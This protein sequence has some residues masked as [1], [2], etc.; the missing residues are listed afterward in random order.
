MPSEQTLEYFSTKNRPTYKQNFILKHSD[1]QGIDHLSNKQNDS[2]QKN[3]CCRRKTKMPTQNDSMHNRQTWR[4][5]KQK[6][7]NMNTDD[8][9]DDTS[10][11][12]TCA[13]VTESSPSHSKVYQ[14]C[15]E[16]QFRHNDYQ[17][18]S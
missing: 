14:Q 8:K 4:L 9:I 13:Q 5:I 10:Y 12:D 2:F 1:V 11:S 15:S 18:Y 16:N 6:N 3:P 17:S 7:Y